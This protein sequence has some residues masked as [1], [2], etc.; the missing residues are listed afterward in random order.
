ETTT[1]EAGETEA[2]ANE[3]GTEEESAAGAKDMHP[4]DLAKSFGG[5]AS[6]LGGGD[7]RAIP[8]PL[9]YDSLKGC[10]DR[11]GKIGK[12]A[13][14]AQDAEGVFTKGTGL[15]NA[16]QN[17]LCVGLPNVVIAPMGAGTEIKAG[18]V[19]KSAISI[20]WAKLMMKR[21]RG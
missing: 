5:F 3:L 10:F 19:C 13:A 1:N 7:G 12:W 21:A 2:N 18:E 11:R 8:R 4:C 16:M 15:S 6:V 20:W 17:T 14:M 9:T